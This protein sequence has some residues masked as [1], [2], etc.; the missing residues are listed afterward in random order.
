M[1]PRLVLL[2]S[3]VLLA[4]QHAQASPRQTSSPVHRSLEAQQQRRLAEQQQRASQR[5]GL[6][7]V[8]PSPNNV[9]G[10]VSRV[11]LEQGFVV[12][13]L[14]S[15]YLNLSGHIITRD[16]QLRTTA[17][18]SVGNAR[19]NRA[20]GLR[21][22][23][24]VPAVGDEIVVV[25]QPIPVNPQFKG[26]THQPTALLPLRAAEA[27]HNAANQSPLTSPTQSAAALQP[28][29]KTTYPQNTP[30]PQS[31]AGTPLQGQHLQPVQAP[32][33]LQPQEHPTLIPANRL[34]DMSVEP[35]VETKIT[36]TV[37]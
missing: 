7:L 10:K 30:P 15:R 33:V 8:S 12:G 2:V 25:S 1:K 13:W 27:L 14:Q 29:S 3:L 32:R 9:I 28:P 16:E 23:S 20:A 21:I 36:V 18:L 4:A 19:N 17:V 5:P 24:G 6:L 34:P 26:D 31:G 37:Q 35:T 22:E 11:N